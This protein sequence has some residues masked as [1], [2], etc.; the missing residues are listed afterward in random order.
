MTNQAILILFNKCARV[1]HFEHTEPQSRNLL[2]K[3]F[4]Y[5]KIIG[6]ALFSMRVIK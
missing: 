4:F 1:I 2:F 6:R 3:G 5:E